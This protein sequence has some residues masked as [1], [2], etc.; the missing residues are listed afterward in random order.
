MFLIFTIILKRSISLMKTS[1]LIS[2]AVNIVIALEIETDYSQ[3]ERK[4][5]L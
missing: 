5:P 3:E 2:M 4:N 1:S